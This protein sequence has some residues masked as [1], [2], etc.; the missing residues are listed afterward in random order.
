[1]Y[2]HRPLCLVVPEGCAFASVALYALIEYSSLYGMCER[3]DQPLSLADTFQAS[4]IFEIDLSN[5]IGY[6]RNSVV[7]IP[8]TCRGL[9]FQAL[10]TP[11]MIQT[12]CRRLT[13]LYI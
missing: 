6:S 9:P 4:N 5:S 8:S 1:M 10:R 12:Q 3:L 7:K 2:P 13:P 11:T